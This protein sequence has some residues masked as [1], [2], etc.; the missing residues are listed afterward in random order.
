MAHPLQQ[1]VTYLQEK[2][3]W[4]EEGIIIPPDRLFVYGG[5]VLFAGIFVFCLSVLLPAL[6]HWQ[7]GARSVGELHTDIRFALLGLVSI[8]HLLS[9]SSP[10][11]L[12]KVHFY[13]LERTDIPPS[14]V[15][16]GR[17]TALNQELVKLMAQGQ[18][19]WLVRLVAFLFLAIVFFTSHWGEGLLPAGVLT[20]LLW[21][22]V[23]LMLWAYAK[24][25][26]NVYRIGR[27]VR[28]FEHVINGQA[29]PEP[30]PHG[31]G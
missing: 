19:L 15:S 3:A 18:S 30:I 9:V 29:K 2:T 11:F 4:G 7:Q 8:L 5:V 21:G 14:G 24:N 31:N 20:I 10:N 23:G 25:G 17:L 28:Q 26:R 6:W 12:L 1:R 22:S 16:T 27:N 13:R